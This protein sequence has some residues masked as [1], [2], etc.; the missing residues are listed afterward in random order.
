MKK[1]EQ[2]KKEEKKKRKGKRERGVRKGEQ[3]K[4]KEKKE[5]TREIRLIFFFIVLSRGRQGKDWCRNAR[6][7]KV[8]ERKKS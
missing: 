7:K 3:L 4:K 1:R 8:K 2:L 5:K 6:E